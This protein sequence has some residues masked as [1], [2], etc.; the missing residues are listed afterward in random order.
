[1][2][3]Y[4]VWHL[5]DWIEEQ[6]ATGIDVMSTTGASACAVFLHFLSGQN[7]YKR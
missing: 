3:K 4:H 5:M 6:L 2:F 1:M 7:W